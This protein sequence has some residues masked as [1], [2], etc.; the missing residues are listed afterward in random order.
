MSTRMTFLGQFWLDDPIFIPMTFDPDL[1]ANFIQPKF[2][3]NLALSILHNSKKKRK[4]GSPWVWNPWALWYHTKMLWKRDFRLTCASRAIF[5]TGY[6]HSLSRLG[7]HF[8][9]REGGGGSLFHW[10]PPPWLLRYWPVP[11]NCHLDLMI[12][13]AVD[14]NL[15][16]ILN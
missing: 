9:S 13:E 1:D 15:S 7:L 6:W 14:K 8:F 4:M 2:F 3:L 16:L 5:G 10:C 11:A 12:T